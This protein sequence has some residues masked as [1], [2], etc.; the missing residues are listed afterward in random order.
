MFTLQQAR[1]EIVR[2]ALRDCSRNQ[3]VR[4]ILRLNPSAQIPYGCTRVSL[5]YK[6]AWQLLP[7]MPDQNLP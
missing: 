2:V 6:L 3:L 4:L 1:A 5:A 7:A